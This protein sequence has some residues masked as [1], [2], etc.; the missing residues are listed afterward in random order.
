MAEMMVRKPFF[1]GSDY[2]DQL[3]K[4]FSIIGT[5]TQD[6]VDIFVKVFGDFIIFS[7]F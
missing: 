2:V 6:E 4:I 1:R 3:K 5:P 7:H